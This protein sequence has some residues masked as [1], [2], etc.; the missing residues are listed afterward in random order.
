MYEW[1]EW[2]ESEPTLSS[3]CCAGPGPYR[4]IGKSGLLG[5]FRIESLTCA[6]KPDTARP[7]QLTSTGAV[8]PTNRA[9]PVRS[10]IYRAPGRLEP[11]LSLPWVQRSTNWATGRAQLVEINVNTRL[12]SR[13]A[14]TFVQPRGMQTPTHPE[15]FRWQRKT[16]V[17]CYGASLIRIPWNYLGQY[18][19]RSSHQVKKGRIIRVSFEFSSKPSTSRRSWPISIKLWGYIQF[20]KLYSK[21]FGM[22][23][24]VDLR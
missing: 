10:F 20:T 11:E 1:T 2:Q 12:A 24:I 23:K 6:S 9:I 17:I 8:A 16:A 19:P 3:A 21:R 14:F 22:F 4:P 5:E 7:T 13:I 15:I 18:D